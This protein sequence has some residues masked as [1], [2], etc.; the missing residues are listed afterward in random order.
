[1][2]EHLL[3]INLLI[4]FV[5]LVFITLTKRDKTVIIKT[6]ATIV[7]G[8]QLWIGLEILFNFNPLETALQFSERIKWIAALRIDYYI[9]IDSI[10]LVFLSVTSLLVFLSVLISWKNENRVKEYFVLLMMVNIGLTGTFSAMNLF[11]FFIFLGIALFAVYLIIGIWAGSNGSNPANRLGIFLLLGYILIL[12]GLILLLYENH[13]HSLN[14]SELISGNTLSP[15][16]QIIISIVFILGFA[17][18]IPVFPFH[19]WLIP[20]IK[21]APAGITVLVISVMTKIGIYGLIRIIVPVMP[22]AANTLA[23]GIA[24]WGLL[25]IIYGAICALGSSDTDQILGYYTLQ[26]NGF[27]LIGLASV[28]GGVGQN[29][30]AAVTGLSGAL[31]VSASHA[32]IFTLLLIM[33]KKCVPD[34]IN[35]SAVVPGMRPVIIL[36]LLGGLGMP[37]FSDFMARFMTILGAYQIPKLNAITII[38]LLGIFSNFIVFLRLFQKMIFYRDYSAKQTVVTFDTNEMF[39]IVI[40]LAVIILLGLFPGF[41]LNI[42]KTGLTRMVEMFSIAVAL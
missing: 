12:L 33:L 42:L 38:S 16:S 20:V 1:M 29:L 35:A 9:G 34:S 5:G 10:N 27:I 37:G 8:L 6:A 30:L 17:F 24:I 3:S 18:L 28:S 31:L 23:L 22:I 36:T 13:L 32:A 14:L 25:N 4:A 15:V 41:P 26:Q 40:L 39:V 21:K 19:S 11:L 2:T 7:S